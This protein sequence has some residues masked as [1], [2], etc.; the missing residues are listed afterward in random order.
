M[1]NQTAA[2]ANGSLVLELR[3]RDRAEC[4]HAGHHHQAARSQHALRE[5]PDHR[6]PDRARAHLGEGR[7][8]TSASFKNM[9]FPVVGYGPWTL[10]GYVPN[11]Y[12]TL[13]ANKSFFMGA[14][15]YNTLIIQYFTNGDAAVAALRSGQLDEIDNLTATAVPGAEG[16]QEHHRCTRGLQR[17]DRDR[18]QPRRADQVGPGTSATATRLCRTRGSARRSRWR[19]T[20]TSWCPRSGTGWPSPGRATCRPPTR[21]GSGP[22]RPP[23]QLQLRP[24]QGQ[25]DPHRGR[26]QD[27]PERDP[28]RPEDRTSRWCCGWA[29]TPTSQPT[30]Q[31][32]PVHRRSG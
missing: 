7:S 1:H 30:P 29:S 10:T 3:Q 25:P 19:S 16:Q 28:H 17:L 22:R 13:T 31:M 9:N 5:R 32:A 11:Q 24:G 2:T 26:V 6:H 20:S 18:A 12:A 8:R 27:G 23:Q 4:D 21:S 14:P 15:K